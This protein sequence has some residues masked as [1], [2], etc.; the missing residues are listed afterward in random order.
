MLLLMLPNLGLAGSSVEDQPDVLLNVEVS[1]TYPLGIA[2]A[3]SHPLA[4]A[5]SLSHPLNVAASLEPL[6]S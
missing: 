5:A 1:I 2:A 3:L 4:V 6:E